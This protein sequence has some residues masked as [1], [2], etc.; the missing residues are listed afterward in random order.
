M[1]NTPGWLKKTSLRCPG[2]SPGRDRALA[3]V[4]ICLLAGVHPLHAR[5]AE[6]LGNAEVIKNT[7]TGAIDGS[8]AKN[9]AVSDPVHA[10]ERVSA[11]ANS[12]GELR[13]N[14]DSLIIVGENSSILLDDF[15][16]GEKGFASA[17]VNVTKGAFRFIT[18]N[19]PKKAFKIKTP[20]SSVGVRGT[21]LDVYV[22]E[23]SGETKVVLL[24]GAIQV[25]SS[26]NSCI[27]TNRTC[28]I[29]EVRSPSEIEKIAFLRSSRRTRADEARQ[30]GL[31][32]NQLRFKRSWRAPLTACGVRA[33]EEARS[34]VP[35]DRGSGSQPGTN[36]TPN[37]RGS[38]STQ[39]SVNIKG[40]G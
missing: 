34:G 13:L 36:A 11:S 3:L 26:G 39:G 17:T 1:C 33:A 30:Y 5:A 8:G 25:C 29:I 40:G 7:V 14:D 28:D 38:G 32:E 22:N 21:V 6:A 37:T 9:L 15:V 31:T 19:S 18:G 23:Q 16:V 20:L 27:T 12:H 24:K 2:T 10:A 4:A 35:Q